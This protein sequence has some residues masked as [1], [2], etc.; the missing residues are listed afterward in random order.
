MCQDYTVLHTGIVLEFHHL[1]MRTQCV[2]SQTMQRQNQRWKLVFL[3]YTIVLV[4][5]C[6]V[7]L[8]CLLHCL[9]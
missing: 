7:A 8:I 1:Q 3:T 5:F 9:W 2:F 6:C 4:L